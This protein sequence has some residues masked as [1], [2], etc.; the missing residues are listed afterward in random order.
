MPTCPECQKQY[1]QRHTCLAGTCA[2]CSMHFK[3]IRN[4]RCQVTKVLS[5]NI[6]ELWEE[7]PANPETD[8]DCNACDGCGVW[9]FLKKNVHGF[10]W[11]Q[12]V[13]LCWDCY[14]IP[15]IIGHVQAMRHRLMDHDGR[16]GKWQCALCSTVLFHQDT[17]EIVRA[18]ERDHIDVFNKSASVWELLV[19]GAPFE[20][21]VH[22]NDKCRNLCVRCHTAVTYAERTVGILGLK[23]IESLSSYVRKRARHQV[24]TLVTAMLEDSSRWMS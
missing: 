19:T 4:H 21:V 6:I 24:N 15:E 14:T 3:N 16:S 1:V 23:K 8:Q 17:H 2:T 18:Y 7:S 10:R 12:G 22:E 11:F 13:H 5:S 9:Y 20:Q